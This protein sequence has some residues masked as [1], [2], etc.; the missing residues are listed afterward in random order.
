M[1]IL[2]VNRSDRQGGAAVACL[3]LAQALRKEGL[4]VQV[5]VLDKQTDLPYVHS[6]AKGLKQKLMSRFAFFAERLEIFLR[7]G[8]T[9][10]DL[11]A[12]SSASFGFD[13]SKHPLVRE[14]D[15]IHLHWINQGYLSLAGIDRLIASGKRVVW[16][17]HDLWAA[18]GICHYP[19][20][21][22]RFKSYCG[23]CKFLHSHSLRDLSSDILNRKQGIIAGAG[24]DF[25]SCSRWL[26]IEA[27]QSLLSAGNNYSAIPNPIDTDQ[28]SPGDIQTAR[29]RLG[30]P[31][32][33]KLILFGAAIVTDRRKGMHYLIEAL[34]YLKD[35]AGDTE[36]VMFGQ[37][38]GSVDFDFGLKVHHLGYLSD[39]SRLIDMYRAVD[40]LVTPSL[41]DNLPNL[42]MEA[43]ACGTPCVGF[44]TGGIPEMITHLQT[45]Y[46]ADYKSPSDL[47]GGIRFILDYPQ[48]GNL[49]KQVRKFVLEHYAEPVVATRYLNIYRKI[50]D[51]KTSYE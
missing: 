46:V 6:F 37:Q 34:Q 27:Q 23:K 3:R 24:I 25:V 8:F 15:I 14:A 22:D 10:K 47:A 7:N 35:R 19:H 28:F 45:G 30:L 29:S 49:K 38:K 11:F 9:R 16:T 36:L 4:D 1:K 20:E 48:P 41:E 40:L 21:C 33:K 17:L 51:K 42:I 43:M 44:R 31:S 18:T 2:L 50:N 13:I 12:V 39:I 26:G 5:L 32:D